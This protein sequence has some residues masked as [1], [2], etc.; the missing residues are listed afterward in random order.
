MDKE[1]WD[2]V[3]VGVLVIILFSG[4]FVFTI[5]IIFLSDAFWFFLS[6]KSYFLFFIGIFVVLFGVFLFYITLK[7]LFSDKGLFGGDSR[8]NRSQFY[9][10]AGILGFGILM[11]VLT[12][13]WW[14]IVYIS[15]SM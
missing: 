4:M 15:Q 11:C 6:S 13:I 9:I 1:K 14:L 5:G 2:Y 7:F 8:I 3:V 10:G 12:F